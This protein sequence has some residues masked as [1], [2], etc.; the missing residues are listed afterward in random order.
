MQPQTF[1]WPEAGLRPHYPKANFGFI[2]GLPQ[3]LQ[4]TVDVHMPINI[5]SCLIGLVYADDISLM[6]ICVAQLQLGALIN[7][8]ALALEFCTDMSQSVHAK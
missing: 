1:Y 7:I 8:N 3:H 4:S 2:D 6:A 5:N